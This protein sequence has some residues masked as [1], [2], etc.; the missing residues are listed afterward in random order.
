M[1]KLIVETDNEWT[2]KKIKDAIHTEAD[3]LKQVIDR[4]QSKL[5]DFEARYGKFDRDSLYGNVDDMD[6]LEWEGELE[7]LER[8]RRELES[9]EE[10]T[11]EY[12]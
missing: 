2:K 5:K 12:R 8:L 7:T 11:F 1:T 10:I 9:L 6:L 4:V 3:I